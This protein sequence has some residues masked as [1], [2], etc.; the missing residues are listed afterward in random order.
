MLEEDWDPMIFPYLYVPSLTHM[1]SLYL[2]FFP[3]LQSL[4]YQLPSGM[5]MFRQSG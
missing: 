4:Q 2:G 5:A 3:A 1:M